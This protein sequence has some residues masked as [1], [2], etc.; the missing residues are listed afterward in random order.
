MS[1]AIA[2]RYWLNFKGGMFLNMSFRL[3]VSSGNLRLPGALG[4][5]NIDILRRAGGQ[6]HFE[7]A[8]LSRFTFHL[9]TTIH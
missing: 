4:L 7:L 2:G 1:S 8:A 9:D 3:A 5:W 6:D